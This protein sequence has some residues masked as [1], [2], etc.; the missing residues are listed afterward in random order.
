M[1][2]EETKEIF[3]SP[4]PEKK[5]TQEMRQE[6][7]DNYTTT[8]D[9]LMHIVGSAENEKGTRY[10][11]TKNSWGEESNDFGGFLYMSES[12]VNL[13][14]IAIMIHKDAIT[15]HIADKLGI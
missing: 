10:Y 8:D 2:E 1:S 6:T 3:K 9:H 4:G 15:K 11:L 12:Y 7:F 13:K 5:I 14:T